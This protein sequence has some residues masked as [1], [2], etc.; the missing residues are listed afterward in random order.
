MTD[1][2]ADPSTVDR[3][4]TALSDLGER[5]LEAL[6]G[7]ERSYPTPPRSIVDGEDREVELRAY[8]EGAFEPLVAMYVDFDPEQRA[9]GTPPVGEGNVREWLAGTLL[10][11]PSVVAWAEGDGSEERAVGHVAFVPDDTGKHELAIFVHP[12]YQR[13]GIGD[14]LMETGFGHARERGVTQVWLTVEPWKRG[15]GKFYSD[16]GFDTVNAYGHAHRMSRYL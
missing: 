5:A 1:R 15:I 10:E 6:P 13:A 4:R 3:L 2:A 9:Q 14:A 12:E 11:G 7:G 16:H 8:D